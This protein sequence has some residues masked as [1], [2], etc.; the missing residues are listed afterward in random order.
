MVAN[1]TWISKVSIALIYTVMI[2]LAI[3]CVLP[4]VHILAMS[5]SDAAAVTA[6]K[7]KLWP[8]GFTTVAYEFVL[9]KPIFLNSFWVSVERVLLGVT[10]NMVL[11]VLLA[12]PLSKEGSQFHFRTVYVWFFVFT[13][14]FSGG[15]IPTYLLIKE[16]NML[17][18]IWALV[19]PQ[20]VQVF[21]VVLMLNF[22]RNLP[23]ELE[24]AAFMDGA[25]HWSTLW[26]IYVPLS[27]PSIATVLLFSAVFQWNEWFSGIIL[28]N[29]PEN[30]PMASYLR[31]V[32][33]EIDHL[34]SMNL[35]Y[36]QL[37]A[38]S[39]RTSKAAQIFLGSLPILLVYPFLQKH[40]VKGITLG[41]VK[42]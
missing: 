22:F 25:G 10:I 32:V 27:K 41:S 37:K 34:L 6:G 26:R 30:Y 16:L 28:M 8:V 24:E 13:M 31:T 18:T 15:L 11:T 4:L 35:D 38:L 36:N 40:F 29:H 5:F 14:L 12:Y 42:G 33:V 20:A 7:V 3:I 2:A 9:T 1:R 17:D 23:R 39:D 19:L 21:H